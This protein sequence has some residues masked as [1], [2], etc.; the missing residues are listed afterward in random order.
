LRAVYHGS[1]QRASLKE[2]AR[3]YQNLVED[4]TG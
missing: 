1:P 2:F 4:S 3:T